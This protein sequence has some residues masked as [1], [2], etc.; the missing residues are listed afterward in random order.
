MTIYAH[1]KVRGLLEGEYGSVFK[2]RSMD[3]D[4]LREYILGDDVKDIDWKATA[5]SGQTLIRR[6]VAIRKHNV[7]LVV[8][9]GRAMKAVSPSLEDKM[10]ISVMVAGV[11]GY[12]A[13]KHSDLVALVAGDQDGVHYMPLTERNVQLEQM[14][15]YIN[16]RAKHD[17][18]KSNTAGV[19]EY[20]AKNIRRKMII[21]V[22][23]DTE[24]IDN[25]QITLLKRLRA[26][27]EILYVSIEDLSPTEPTHLDSDIYDIQE[28][29]VLTHFIRSNKSLAK[30]LD[31]AYKNRKLS[32]EKSLQ[33][34]GINSIVISSEKEVITGLF[35]LLEKQRHAKK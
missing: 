9:T 5:R 2:G 21:V 33:R 32:N 20:I 28:P 14:L 12:L 8:N 15:Q 1:Q 30:E 19:F 13:Q 3:F 27:H 10:D 26:Q 4:D 17:G 24:L 25:D 11:M 35:K 23:G 22:I 29:V 34:I 6:Y 31:E 7:L 18:P 16:N